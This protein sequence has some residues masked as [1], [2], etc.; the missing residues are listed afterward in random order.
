MSDRYRIKVIGSSRHWLYPARL[1]AE[2][3]ISTPI[4]KTNTESQS[5]KNT[6]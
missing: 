4:S 2:R 6:G 5:L 1:D 3:G